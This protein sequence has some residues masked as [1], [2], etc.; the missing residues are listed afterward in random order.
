VIPAGGNGAE[1]LDRLRRLLDFQS[2]A[3]APEASRRET[4]ATGG[5]FRTTGRRSSAAGEFRR[6]A[7]VMKD[8]A[9][10]AELTC[11]LGAGNR[12]GRPEQLAWLASHSICL[13]AAYRG[14]LLLHGA[15]AEL[16]GS[17]VILA[18]S[19]GAGKSTASRRLPEGWTSLSDDATLLLPDASGVFRAR[20]WPS[21]GSILLNR[22]APGRIAGRLVPVRAVFF[23]EHADTDAAVRAG[24]GEASCLLAGSAAQGLLI[25]NDDA[26]D[27]RFRD[28]RLRTLETAVALARQTPVFRLR[29]SLTGRFWET[30][31]AALR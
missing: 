7:G 9:R 6:I 21:A 15:L 27:Q 14:G 22:P 30:I 29:L 17:G 10:H 26:A 2:A 8:L 19:S 3:R 12:S 28:L 1:A 13:H 23:L 18:G 20:P 31:E 24:A 11:T 5:R 4:A 25:P 16:D